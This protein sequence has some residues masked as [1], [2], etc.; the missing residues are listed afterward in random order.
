MTTLFEGSL[1][2]DYHQFLL[3]DA[4]AWPDAPVF[5]PEAVL[6]ARLNLAPGMLVV[7]TVRNMRVPVRVLL[8][9]ARPA[10]DLAAFDHVAE[11]P[12]HAPSGRIAI[13]GLTD[14]QDS[15]ATAAV[16]QL[17]LRAL[18][19]FAG[20]GTLSAD[21]LEG[22]DRYTVHLFPG[23]ETGVTVLRQWEEASPP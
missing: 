11:A 14:A 10:L 23:T 5:W 20:L 1:L 18:V 16:P 22:A 17:P 6:R 19:T 2:A 8:H 9:P 4:V 7:S 12:L 3:C 15:A 13:L 21:G